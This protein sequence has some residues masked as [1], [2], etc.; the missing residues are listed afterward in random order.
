MV[1]EK[2]DIKGEDKKDSLSNGKT[3]Y[4]VGPGEIFWK[5][6]LAGFGR[7]LGGAFVYIIFLL[8]A[9]GLVVRFVLPQFAPII[10]NFTNLSKSLESISKT[11]P[12]GNNI[13]PQNLDLQKIF[14]Q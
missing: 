10:D 12:G 2:P 6:F 3:I 9:T 11:K 7:G 13:V 8:I 5:N 1:E 4:D 14:G